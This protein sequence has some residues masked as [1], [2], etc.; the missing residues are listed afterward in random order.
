MP[1]PS[2]HTRVRSSLFARALS[3]AALLTLATAASAHEGHGLPGINHWHGIDAGAFGL[4]GA[5]IVGLWL[6]GRK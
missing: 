3:A 5:F 1:T 4:I 2:L 6:L